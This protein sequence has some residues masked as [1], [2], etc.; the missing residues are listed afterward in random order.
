MDC[1]DAWVAFYEDATTPYPK[2]G[3]ASTDARILNMADHTKLDSVA[4]IS[5]EGA[6]TDDDDS[7]Q[8]GFIVWISDQAAP[9][10][11]LLLID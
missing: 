10:C 4:N 6:A 2:G 5:F 9:A 8:R 1:C 3:Y 7:E 11:G